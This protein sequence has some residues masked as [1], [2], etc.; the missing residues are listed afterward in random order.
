MH[1]RR[2]LLIGLGLA[3]LAP[4][5]SA[6]QAESWTW[7]LG[8]LEDPSAHA[9]YESTARQM[10]EYYQGRGILTGK[11]VHEAEL[12]ERPSGRLVH[13]GPLQ[14]FAHPEWLAPPLEKVSADAL[15]IGGR[16][17][18]APRTG[19]YLRDGSDEHVL[20]TGLSLQGFKDVFSFPTGQHPFSATIDGERRF[21]GNYVG[22]A[23]EAR[24]VPFLPTLPSAP[25]LVRLA[26][27]DGVVSFRPLQTDELSPP[28]KEALLELTGDQRVL[29]VGETH[30]NV[31][32][33]AL[34]NELLAFL[35]EERELKAVFL[36]LGYSLSG[37][38]DHYVTIEDDERAR[39]FFDDE[40]H[41]Y[42]PGDS[43]VELVELLRRWNRA[44]P[45]RRVHVSCV[46][47]EWKGQEVIERTLVPYF[48]GLDL[49]TR[50]PFTRLGNS[51]LGPILRRQLDGALDEAERSGHVGTFP[52]LTPEYIR[53]V[54][55]NLGDTLRLVDF[56]VGR[57]RAIQRNI[58]EY[59]APLLED[60]LALF[61]G[62]SFHAKK[63]R[64]TGEGYWT[65]A[66][67]LQHEYAPTQ[68]KVRTLYLRGL[69]VGFAQVAP[70]DDSERLRSA[71]QYHDFIA[72]FRRGTEGGFANPKDHYLLNGTPPQPH[73]LLIARA[74]DLAQAQVVWVESVD[75]ERLKAKGIALQSHA[76]KEFDAAI[77]VL[78]SQ[79]EPN[80]KR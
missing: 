44:H 2:R 70:L 73:E 27:F 15:T 52:F 20:F 10:H 9:D 45:D 76:L 36:E 68:G 42:L 78:R 64:P 13:I 39:E 28:V 63:A 58:T 80:R 24:A 31:G 18:T 57:Q 29:F 62:G 43:Q 65:D 6:A 14:S 61:K 17:F 60:G 48:E 5:S 41:P 77:Y 32:V 66:A 69:G 12:A 35:L 72:R 16:D 50:I 37:Y 25:E 33:N 75:E 71:D 26:E 74:A 21:E 3:W 55:E 40:L 4:L 54:L 7:I 59:A 56:N 34:F 67:Y 46:D 79:L 30:W 11:L 8:R 38:L 49:E 22:G 51:R 47:L 53:R 23:L 1:P 19:I